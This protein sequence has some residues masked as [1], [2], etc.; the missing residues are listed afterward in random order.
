MSNDT[1]FSNLIKN[2]MENLKNMI[3]V[4]TIVG[5][6]ITAPND[7]TIIP[8]SRLTFGF[9]SGGSEFPVKN[10][11]VS[12]EYPFGG[13][14]SSGVSIK[15]TALL[16]IKND[17]VRLIPIN[18]NNSTTIIDSIPQIIDMVENFCKN[19]STRKENSHSSFETSF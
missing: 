17:S 10:P 7:T 3:D 4:E 15:P 19:S 5:N 8:L 18:N 1:N 2:T 11:H 6:P 14:S 13:G 9:V 16:V 12:K